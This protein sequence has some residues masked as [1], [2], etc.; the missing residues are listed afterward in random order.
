MDTG[1]GHDLITP[2]GASKCRVAEAQKIIFGTAN[3][4]TSARQ[5]ARIDGK[6]FQGKAYPY[7]LS[8]TPWV[9]SLGLRVMEIGYSF[10]WISG[11]IPTLIAPDVVRVELEA[12]GNVPIQ[13]IG[14]GAQYT[15]VW[16]TNPR[17]IVALVAV[18]DAAPTHANTAARSREN[19]V[20]ITS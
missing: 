10:V 9:L 3:R 1:S 8:D 17:P 12:Q 19:P 13:R 4:R 14:D 5:A 11:S 7:L 15:T 6:I 18:L 16:P 20:M 2:A